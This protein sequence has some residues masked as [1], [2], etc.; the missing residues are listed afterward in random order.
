VTSGGEQLSSAVMERSLRLLRAGLVGVEL[1]PDNL[2]ETAEDV[3]HRL[4]D[5]AREQVLQRWRDDHIELEPGDVLRGPSDRPA[6]IEDYD[7]STGYHWKRLQQYLLTEKNR[8]ETVIDALDTSSNEILAQLADPREGGPRQF[9]VKGLVLGYVQSGKTANF[10]AVIA[11]AYD[12]GYRTVIV[13][14]GLHNSLRRQTQLRLEDELGLVASTPDRPTVDRNDDA[15]L[16]TRMTKPDSGGDFNQGTV[17]D[18][19]ITVGRTIMVMKKNATVLR[20]L[21]ASLSDLPPL[22][23]PV[24]VIDDEA[25]QASINTGGNRPSANQDEPADPDEEDTLDQVT[26]LTVDDVA[27]ASQAGGV[28][29]MTRAAVRAETDPSIIN[30]L[31]RGLLGRMRRVAYIGYTATPFANVLIG[32]DYT[33]SARGEDLY[34]R[35][36]IFSL[37]RPHGYVGAERLFGRQ[38]LGAESEPVAGLNMIREVEEWE[39]GSLLP[40]SKDPSPTELPPTLQTALMDFVLAMAARDVRTQERPASS[41]LIHASQLTAQQDALAVLIKDYLSVLRQQWLYDLKGVVKAEL[42]QRWEAEFT[43]VTAAVAP[44]RVVGFDVIEDAVG[45]ILRRGVRVY[46][47]NNTS[48]DELDYEREPNLRGVL[49]GGNKLSRG[50]TLEGLLVSYYVRRANNYDT[51]LQM[52]RWFGYRE[53]YVDL[54]RLYTTAGLSDNFRDLA[55]FE[56]ELRLEI[57]RY[58]Q[59][60]LTPAEFG[61][62]ISKHPAMEITARNRMGSAQ[63]VVYN[64]A[65]TLQQTSAFDL[66]DTAWLQRNLDA[67][68]RFLRALGTTNYDNNQPRARTWT[69]VDWN[70]IY[71]LLGD[72]RT[73]SGSTK[74]V[75]DRLRSYI[76][77][78]AAQHGELI[79]WTVVLRGLQDID[80]GLGEEDLWLPGDERVF[81]MLRSREAASH[82]SIGTL[83]DPASAG[84][85]GDEDLDLTQEDRDVAA[86][87]ARAALDKDGK[88]GVYPMALRAR[89]SPEQGLLVLYPISRNSAPR[90]PGPNA[91][92]KLASNKQP[93][94]D[95]PE[96][97][98]TVIGLAVALP[99]SDSPAANR[100]YVVGSA[101]AAPV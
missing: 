30:G 77:A 76:Q 64:Y 3:L 81:C 28:G 84:S 6:W 54:T 1:T 91:T 44:D 14:S 85:R 17:D 51:L 12:A 55:T 4:S 58:E 7:P 57:R 38:A 86:Q 66:E 70:D 53:S 31:I 94:F 82:T 95:H 99:K 65:A 16:I 39:A 87:I 2:R 75:G 23:Q 68:R 97:G 35:D 36:F 15:H 29:R 42:R 19:L 69:D 72:Y 56:E 50:L 60:G 74:F 26:D 101:G 71:A 61:P 9:L 20:R 22:S 11:K 34:P 37:P 49:V 73:F 52:G 13:L 41:M 79:R 83:V 21:E 27:G 32:H 90:T 93:L 33:D 43:P 88:K 63:T 25:D 98:V 100:E 78:Q 10:A 92:T 67:T 89:R 40:R 96:R 8:S 24:L 5:D 18:N 47:L 59:L 80:P 62:R 46:V 48:T 45:D